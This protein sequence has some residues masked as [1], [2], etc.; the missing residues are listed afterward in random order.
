SHRKGIPFAALPKTLQDAITVCRRLSIRYIWID[1]LCI[2]QGDEQEWKR[3]SLKMAD[4]FAN[5]TFAM[6][7]DSSDAVERGFLDG[8]RR[9]HGSG[10][11]GCISPLSWDEPLN[12]RAWSLSEVIFPNRMVHFTSVEMVWECN[13]IRRWE[14]GRQ[15]VIPDGNVSDSSIS[16]R[17]LRN[18]DLAATCS[19]AD[20]YQ[21]WADITRLF[22]RRQ[23]NNQPGRQDRD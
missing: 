17:V 21:V 22:S 7:A 5:A 8:A 18:A 16:F 9:P 12:R 20:L 6:A 14:C 15:E 2:T 19:K 10:R 23:I 11:P 1:A 3:E 4:V 13:H